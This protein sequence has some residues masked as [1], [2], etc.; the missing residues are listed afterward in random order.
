MET[1]CAHKHLFLFPP[2]ETPDLQALHVKVTLLSTQF[3][4]AFCFPS[5][6]FAD[7]KWISPLWNSN[8]EA[9]PAGLAAD[10]II[11]ALEESC[12][13]TRLPWA[14]PALQQH[15]WWTHTDG[16]LR[17]AALQSTNLGFCFWA[18]ST[19]P[20][21]NHSVGFFR[22]LGKPTMSEHVLGH[23]H[24]KPAVLWISRQRTLPSSA[25]PVPSIL[26]FFSFTLPSLCQKQETAQVFEYKKSLLKMYSEIL[27][28]ISSITMPCLVQE[29]KKQYVDS[30]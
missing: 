23:R 11:S 27:K 14:Y 22:T 16:S 10:G 9:I 28:H 20:Y 4:L 2:R 19:L 18:L 13:N 1:A 12:G 25:A 17:A 21:P 7:E 6:Y 15:D 8:S 26:F 3:A 5:P 24:C 30:K 29:M